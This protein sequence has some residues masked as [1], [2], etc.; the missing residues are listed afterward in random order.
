MRY[1]RGR[2]VT[3]R[4]RGLATISL[5][6]VMKLFRLGPLVVAVS[7]SAP[8]EVVPHLFRDAAPI[9]WSQRLA[10]S[11]MARRGASLG[12]DGAPKARWDY[13]SGLFAHSLMELG[14]ETGDERFTGFAQG[15]TGSFI[16]PDGAIST[17][18]EEEFNIDMI[19]PGRAVLAC[20]RQ[21]REERFKVAAAT[22]RGQLSKHPR[23]DDGGFWHKKKYPYQMWLDGLY[24]GSPFLAEYGAVFH[25]PAAFDEVVKQ[26]LLMD[27]HS[28]DAR[29]GLHCHGWDEKRAQTWANPQTGCSPCFWGRSV[30]WYAMAIVDSLEH[31]PPDHPGVGDV[32]QVL[33]RLAEGVKRHQDPVSGLWWQVLDQGARKGNYQEASASAMFVYAIA[34]GVNR[35]WLPRDT[36][37]PCVVRGYEGML[38]D[39][40]R[41]DGWETSLTRVCEVAGLGFTTA[42]GRPRD[43]SFDY[44]ISEPVI[45]ND[46]KGVGPFIL[47]GIE[48]GRL[49]NPGKAA[50]KMNVLLIISDDMR[51]ELG[52]Y[53]STLARTPNLDKLAATGVRFARAYCQFPLCNPSRASMLTG[54]HPSTMGVLGN[55]TWFGEKHP[56]IVSLPKHFKNSGYTSV[57]V[58]KI[59]HGG[60]DDTEAWSVDGQART[61][62]GVPK[63]GAVGKQ[64]VP[65]P[66]PIDPDARDRKSDQWIVLEGDGSAHGD[67]KVADRTIRYLNE[68][69]DRP[70]FIGCGFVKPHSPPEAP[71]WC[72]DLWDVSNIPLPPDF[73]PRPTVPEGFP[74]GSIR[75]KNSDLFIARDASPDAAREM[76]RAYLASS[77]FMDWN[78]GRVLAELDR[79]GLREKTIVVFWGDHG[80]QL[81]EKG[82]WSKAGSLWEQGTRTPLIIC[83]PRGKSAGTASPRIV[84][85]VDLYP[86]LVE[87]CGL[88]QPAGLEGRSLLPLLETP[89]MPWDHP[90]RTVWSEDG[91][92]L[93]GVTVRTEKWRFAE[94]FGRGAGTMLIDPAADPHEMTNL[95]GEPENELVVREF[96]AMVR[97][98]AKGLET[99][100]G[101]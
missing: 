67:S 47:A 36:Y 37:L 65:G 34:K 64:I 94:F 45:E 56:D 2:I 30:G 26:I 42:N 78:V 23:T 82:K 70:F 98:Y 28:Y 44:Y 73:A 16:S 38:R 68:Y 77:S 84:E 11:E 71:Q 51:T 22:L 49:V 31:L 55:R 18:R 1:V 61:L 21:S 29:A 88:E 58:G 13:T 81:G 43:G 14:R 97:A 20:Y 79:T 101:K 10:S 48:V 12:K 96:S 52:C 83:D 87:L 19:L 62:A 17:Y 92:T 93:S 9:E 59:F 99:T 76:I 24:M 5:M 60:I 3:P 8:A 69:K 85:M 63:D 91:K 40:I 50:G 4:P 80:Y 27:R 33:L 75:P 46:L 41:H 15:L 6:N 25:E 95:A 74:A 57:R 86:T 39:F 53:A 72:Y 35:G 90:A 32:K 54:R 100:A 89:G 7:A 66:K